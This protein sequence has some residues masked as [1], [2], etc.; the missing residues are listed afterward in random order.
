MSLPNTISPV[1]PFDVILSETTNEMIENIEA[2]ADGS[3]LDDGA[4]TSSKLATGAGEPGGAWTSWTPTFS[5][6][7]IGSGT[8]SGRYTQIGKTVIFTLEVTLS[9]STMGSIPTFT[10]PVTSRTYKTSFM[11]GSGQIEDVSVAGYPLIAKWNST[12]V[13]RLLYRTTVDANITSSAPMSWGNTDNFSLTGTYE[14][15]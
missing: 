3:G 15:A 5:N 8:V 14:A 2:L 11:V 4:V 9:S 7:T 13:A 1:S 12:T 10:L 6:F